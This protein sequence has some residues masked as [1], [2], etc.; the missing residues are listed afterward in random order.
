MAAPTMAGDKQC[1]AK[2]DGVKVSR[3]YVAGEL[4]FG[5]ADFHRKVVAQQIGL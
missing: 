5:D 1:E 4:F 3:G 2:F